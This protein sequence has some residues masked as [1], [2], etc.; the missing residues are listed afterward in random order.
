[1]FAEVEYG[2]LQYDL[3]QYGEKH[4]KIFLMMDCKSLYDHLKC[5]GKFLEDKH[6]AIWTAVLRGYAAA[7]PGDHGKTTTRWVTS[8]C[9]LADGLTKLGLNKTHARVD[10]ERLDEAP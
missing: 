4:M 2:H 3:A 5:E 9:Q 8:P 10:H 7:W 1:M 6:T